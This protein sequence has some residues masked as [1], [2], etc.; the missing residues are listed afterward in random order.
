[1]KNAAGIITNVVISSIKGEDVKIVLV[2]I[3]DKNR[4]ILIKVCTRV[5]KKPEF[6]KPDPLL[7]LVQRH[8]L[9]KLKSSKMQQVNRKNL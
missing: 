8:T 6:L 1:M 9:L 3:Q 7:G 2:I 4:L 5:C